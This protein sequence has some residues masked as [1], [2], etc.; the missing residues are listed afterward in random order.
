MITGVDA[1]FYNNWVSSHPE[2]VKQS[3]PSTNADPATAGADTV[4][5]ISSEAWQ[6]MLKEAP[7]VYQAEWVPAGQVIDR[8]KQ[9]YQSLGYEVSDEW[10]TKFQNW[11]TSSDGVIG[12]M[13]TL[14]PRLS[15]TW[16]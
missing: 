6:Q 4:V 8:V 2:L 10:L 13:P 16:A 9:D 7:V 14:P 12:A 11:A 15:D 3:I 5:S 1:A